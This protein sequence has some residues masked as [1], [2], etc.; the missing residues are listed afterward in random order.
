MASSGVR[1]PRP[2]ASWRRRAL[3]DAGNEGLAVREDGVVTLTTDGH[4]SLIGTAT[5]GVQL[6]WML[7]CGAHARCCT[8]HAVTSKSSLVCRYC[9]DAADLDEGR[10]GPSTHE[11][12]FFSAMVALRLDT[13]LRAEVQPPWW[14]GC[15]DFVDARSGLVIQVDGEGH[16]Q[17][18]ISNVPCAQV[19]RMDL[20]MCEAAWQAGCV[21]LRVHYSDIPGGGGA[22]LAKALMTNPLSGP[23]VGL[24]AHYNLPM[25][26]STL[27]IKA[28]LA[29]IR[30]LAARLNRVSACVPCSDFAGRLWFIRP[31]VPAHKQMPTSKPPSGASKMAQ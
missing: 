12:A 11:R 24:S 5:E 6:D 3:L 14:H 10:R 16:F 2:L 22:D 13:R 28:R 26:P 19:L 7:D 1:E 30:Q 20:D 9:T 8:P 17:K 29:L 21:L 15:V 18:K 4:T 25:P 23:L 31:D 27:A